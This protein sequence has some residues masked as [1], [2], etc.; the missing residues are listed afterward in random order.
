[1]PTRPSTVSRRALA[2]LAAVAVTVPLLAACGQDNSELRQ[3]GPGTT[4]YI[5]AWD[6]D[7]DRGDQALIEQKPSGLWVVPLQAPFRRTKGGRFDVQVELTR[8]GVW[9]VDPQGARVGRDHDDCLADGEAYAQLVTP[10][11]QL[12]WES[13][14]ARNERDN[15]DCVTADQSR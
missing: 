11:A 4:V 13:G 2:G 5:D 6:E 9:R 8:E 10:E 12:R 3:I 1:M 7:A 14:S 15:D